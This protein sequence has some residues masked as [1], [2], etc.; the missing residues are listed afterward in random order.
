M[1]HC[2]MTCDMGRQIDYLTM[3]RE[4]TQDQTV[5]EKTPGY[6]ELVATIGVQVANVLYNAVMFN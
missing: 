5:T 3:V 1:Y 4:E 6:W 2:F